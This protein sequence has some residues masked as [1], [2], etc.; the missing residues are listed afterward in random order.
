M[1]ILCNT[2]VEVETHKHTHIR[3]LASH[4][5]KQTHT[6]NHLGAK[7]MCVLGVCVML[8]RSVCDVMLWSG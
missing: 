7:A 4:T 5:I 6:I 3:Y 2:A 8:R 1:Y